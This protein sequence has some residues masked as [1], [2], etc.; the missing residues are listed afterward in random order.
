MNSTT[1]LKEPLRWEVVKEQ[2]G[3]MRTKVKKFHP[4]QRKPVG[5]PVLGENEKLQ[6]ALERMRKSTSEW[7]NKR[8]SRQTQIVRR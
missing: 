7:E 1:W 8:N 5:A 4:P 3:N 2:S 6:R